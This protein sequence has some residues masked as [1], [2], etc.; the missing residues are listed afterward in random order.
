MLYISRD[1]TKIQKRARCA[2]MQPTGKEMF[3]IVHVLI[4]QKR[5]MVYKER[6]GYAHALLMN[7]LCNTTFV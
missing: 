6:N 7:K 4:K 1:H 3:G 5:Y 2:A